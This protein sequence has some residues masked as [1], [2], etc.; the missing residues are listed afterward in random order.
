ML[1]TD[2]GKR[3]GRYKERQ[4]ITN[5]FKLRTSETDPH[6]SEDHVRVLKAIRKHVVGKLYGRAGADDWSDRRGHVFSH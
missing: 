3:E 1:G 5:R 4:R 6:Q 2:A